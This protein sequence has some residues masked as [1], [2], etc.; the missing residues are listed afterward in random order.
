[1]RF[2][3]ALLLLLFCGASAAQSGRASVSGWV[4]FEGVA[5]ND[6]QPRATVRLVHEGEPP[7]SYEVQTDEHG[8]F[9]FKDLR[10]LGRCRLEVS[11]KGYEPYS[12]GLYLPSDFIAHWAVEL[13]Q[14]E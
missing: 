4:S 14:A 13:R 2:L 12:A 9:D 5:Y 10:A 3:L 8:H 7:A 1:M 11:A 6:P